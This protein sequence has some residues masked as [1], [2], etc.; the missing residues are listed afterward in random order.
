MMQPMTET[1]QQAIAATAARLIAEE[2]LDY[3]AAKKKAVKQMGLAGDRVD[4]PDNDQ[5]EQALQ[6]W[7][8]EQAE[9]DPQAEAERQ[10][11]L[12]R[13]REL[14]L[15]WM[16]RLATW[17]P[18]LTGA[19]WNGTANE[20]SV[21]HLALFTDD[22]KMLEIELLNR[23][24]PY[25]VTEPGARHD[26]A[27]STL[28]VH[29]EDIPVILTLYPERLRHSRAKSADGRALRGDARAVRALLT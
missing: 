9:D 11:E 3:Q 29:D 4:W 15:T 8:A 10:A 17:N 26:D 19:V 6:D 27:T 25:E 20:H 16:D 2:G 13:L 12:R 28:V 7:Y 5:I 14:A 21:V 23:D 24:L 22:D 18:W 1:L